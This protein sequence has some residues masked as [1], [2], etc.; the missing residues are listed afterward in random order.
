MS[1]HAST[2]EEGSRAPHAAT[3]PT[4]YSLCL[5]KT[6]ES[7][8]VK[9]MSSLGQSCTAVAVGFLGDSSAAARSLL[10]LLAKRL[11]PPL[12]RNSNGW[13]LYSVAIINKIG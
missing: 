1:A 7:G 2:N 10:D 8:G 5:Q 3:R 6:K 13:T 4:E 9:R 11:A 12:N